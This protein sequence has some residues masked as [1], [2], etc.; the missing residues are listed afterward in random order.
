MKGTTSN[1]LHKA[2]YSIDRQDKIR[3]NLPLMTPEEQPERR[4]LKTHAWTKLREYSSPFSNLDVDTHSFRQL[5][6]RTVLDLKREG[7]IIGAMVVDKHKVSFVSANLVGTPNP[8]LVADGLRYSVLILR[9]DGTH[10]AE[11]DI[12]GDDQL[13]EILELETPKIEEHL[14]E[15]NVKKA[16]VATSPNAITEAYDIVY[17]LADA[18]YA[19]RSQA[20]E[21]N[22][23]SSS[24]N[25]L[26]QTTQAH[27]DALRIIGT[28]RG[29][30]EK[31]R[32]PFPLRHA[33]WSLSIGPDE[34]I[35]D[36]IS[37]PEK[38]GDPT[39]KVESKVAIS[40]LS[41][42]K[43]IQMAVEDPRS[44][45]RTEYAVE[46][47]NGE[48]RIQTSGGTNPE[49]P[50]RIVAR[51][52]EPWTVESV[53]KLLRI[54]SELFGNRMAPLV[55]RSMPVNIFLRRFLRD[56]EE[57]D[58]RQTKLKDT[59]DVAIP[60][61]WTRVQMQTSGDN[62]IERTFDLLDN[63][64]KRGT[65]IVT[66]VT[67]GKNKIQAID[68]GIYDDTRVKAKPNRRNG[69]SQ[70]YFLELV[71]IDEKGRVFVWE[72]GE[73][74]PSSKSTRQKVIDLIKRGI[75]PAYLSNVDYLRH[76]KEIVDETLDLIPG[77]GTERQ[78]NGLQS[79]IETTISKLPTLKAKQ[80]HRRKHEKTA[81]EHTQ[82]LISEAIV[83]L[84][85]LQERAA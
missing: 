81:S 9:G 31:S 37:L 78:R 73:L 71:R 16:N 5:G 74:K 68:L 8:N 33:E 24:R 40:W 18:Y 1:R 34:C 45:L 53:I 79:S 58:K 27:E 82:M 22:E 39:I 48:L 32:V 50:L 84:G 55:G 66:P 54:T 11:H 3:Y 76:A 7:Q 23:A 4:E 65:V 13:I 59:L 72:R 57:S 67:D 52:E 38:L 25:D 19:L 26:R 80:R 61:E 83:N 60:D 63:G 49:D 10:G 46:R 51:Q 44:H 14:R 70:D 47:I 29:K 28:N 12:R 75:Q 85:Q 15:Y 2:A 17:S 30:L 41:E 69:P 20:A 62:S 64:K 77:S 6:S 36:S 21:S 42:D 35:A 43:R 56:L